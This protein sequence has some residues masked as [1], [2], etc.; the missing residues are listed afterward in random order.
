MSYQQGLFPVLSKG[1][2]A[3]NIFDAVIY[4]PAIA[5]EARPGQFVHIRIPS[6]ILR[7]PISI[8]GIDAAAG[9]I[10][11]IY[12]IRG[13][14]TKILADIK[15]GDMMDVLG[16]LGHGY[17]M[18]EPEK[19]CV[20]VGG[21]IGVPPLLPVAQHYGQNTTAVLG[22]RSAQAAILENDFQK[23]GASVVLCTDDGS[24]GRKGFVTSALEE[25]LQSDSPDVICACG[26]T[27]MLKKVVEI[28]QRYG[29]PSEISLEE[30]MA[31]GVGACLGCACKINRNGKEIFLHVCKDGPVFSGEEVVF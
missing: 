25:L 5:Q 27:I 11:I 4:C 22:F 14:G 3:K 24:M 21:G 1:N 6:H 7:R 16:P 29:I 10:R 13:E 18:Q 31:C 15:A 12:E 9:T 30:R 8:A 17:T 20:V 23:A 28:A 26:P 19:K 2:L